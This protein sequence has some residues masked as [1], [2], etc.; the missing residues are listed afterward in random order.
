MI[1][2]STVFPKVSLTW[3]LIPSVVVI[4]IQSKSLWN[5]KGISETFKHTWNQCNIRMLFKTKHTLWSSFMKT[6]PERDLLEVAQCVY[7]FP[8]ECG[9]S[10]IRETCRS[11][12]VWFNEHR[13]RLKEGK[14]KVKLS[15]CLT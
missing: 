4:W 12:A 7:S 2:S 5:M 10:Y 14:V 9:R 1:F 11:L 13:H 8:C 6:R 3:L 15:L